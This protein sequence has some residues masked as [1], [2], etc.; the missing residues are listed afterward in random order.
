MLSIHPNLHFQLSKKRSRVNN[1][2]SLKI[3]TTIISRKL[4][5]PGDK[6]DS[7][8]TLKYKC[9]LTICIYQRLQHLRTIC[10][11]LDPEVDSQFPQALIRGL[12][13]NTT[14]VD[15]VLLK[16]LLGYLHVMLLPLLLLC[17][18]LSPEI[19]SCC[20]A[21]SIILSSKLLFNK[22]ATSV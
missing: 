10:F 2:A 8:F 14:D 7:S 21:A 3:K 20:T 5:N 12:E 11:R 15:L 19:A 18:L 17:L 4:R 9:I 16:L 13:E 1:S 22:F 6:S